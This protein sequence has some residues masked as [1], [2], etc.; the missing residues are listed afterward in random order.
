MNSKLYLD[1]KALLGSLFLFFPLLMKL[2]I[3]QGEKKVGL[4]QSK[5]VVVV[6]GGGEHIVVVVVVY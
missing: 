5:V 3:I 1:F 6:P 4:G 2:G